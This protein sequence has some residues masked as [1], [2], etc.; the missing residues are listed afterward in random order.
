MKRALSLALLAAL[1]L[2]PARAEP[3]N[4]VIL[5][6]VASPARASDGCFAVL[7]SGRV[8]FYFTQFQSGVEDYSPAQVDEI[9]SDD[10]G[11]TW[12]RPRVVVPNTAGQNVSS[13]SLLRLADGRLAFFYERKNSTL[14]LHPLMCVSA[15]EGATW[16]EPRPLFQAP[17]YFVLNNDRVIQT[18]RGRLIAPVAYHRTL[19]PR[20]GGYEAIDLR[21]IVIWYLSDD[22]GLTWREADTWWG[23]PV[24][25]RD[26][27][28]EPGAV[29]LADGSLF[30]WARTDVGAQYGFRSVDGGAT[31]SAPEPT[32][33]A[34]PCSPAAIKRLPGS[35]DLLA[36]YNDHSGRFPYPHD[37]GTYQGRS[38]LVAAISADG[39]RTWPAPR[40]IETDLATNFCYPSFLVVGDH[41]LLAYLAAGSG[42]THSF[43][44]RLRRIGLSWFPPPR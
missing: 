27:L 41:V 28:Q 26:G 19:R 40:A 5:R 39:G 7:R 30:S 25:G 33:L 24:A 29:E 22:C 6:I 2:A 12:S 13:A 31:W 44:L 1:A 4:Q 32:R 42:S 38:P 15:D 20:P 11:D 21:G 37:T 16:S 8:I 43:E 10:G 9:H 17:G 3:E 23:L 18:R 35:A 36:V 34:T 14:D